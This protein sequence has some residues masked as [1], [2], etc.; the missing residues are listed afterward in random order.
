MKTPNIFVIFFHLLFSKGNTD[1]DAYRAEVTFLI[2]IEEMD[3]LLFCA[4]LL[5]TVFFL[6]QKAA[7]H[8][9]LIS[10]ECLCDFML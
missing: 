3:F 8:N 6:F 1:I 2:S 4:A 7:I 9:T 5:V 10:K